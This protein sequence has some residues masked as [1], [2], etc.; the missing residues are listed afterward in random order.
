MLVEGLLFSFKN[1]VVD[2]DQGWQ[3]GPLLCV[4]FDWLKPLHCDE[5]VLEAI[6]GLTKLEC[7]D[8][9]ARLAEVTALR[10]S[11]SA[12]YW[13]LLY[14]IMVLNDSSKRLLF[15]RNFSLYRDKLCK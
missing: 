14:K 11:P 2:L 1:R 10:S 5:D 13:S 15:L 8:H 9:S 4:K 7:P 3:V 12:V 6:Y